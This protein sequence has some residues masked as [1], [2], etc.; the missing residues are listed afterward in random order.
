MPRDK[1]MER[2][3]GKRIQTIRKAK[4][5][6]QQQLA[7]M[8]G[9]STNYLS[10]LERGK[11]SPRMDKLVLIMNRLECSADDVFVDVINIRNQIKATRLSERIDSL[12]AGD[13]DKV[14]AILETVVEQ[15]SRSV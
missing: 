9:I 13:Q 11:S 5:L 4:G 1:Q 12:P 3:I 10:D 7:E 6:T 15:S 14:L 8:V 2:I